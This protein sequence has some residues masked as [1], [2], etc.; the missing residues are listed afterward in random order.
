MDLEKLW[1]K[2]S[3]TVENKLGNLAGHIQWDIPFPQILIIYQWIAEYMFFIEENRILQLLEKKLN[4]IF[5]KFALKTVKWSAK[6]L[7]ERSHKII[8]LQD[9]VTNLPPPSFPQTCELYRNWKVLSWSPAAS[10][11]DRRPLC[12]NHPANI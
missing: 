6:K 12:S 8:N 4:F 11:V 5:T 7:I 2:L 3:F 10:Y 9:P 1:P